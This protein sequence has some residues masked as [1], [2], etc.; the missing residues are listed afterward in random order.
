MQ[1][2]GGWARA[3][4]RC[5]PRWSRGGFEFVVTTPG[6]SACSRLSSCQFLLQLPTRDVCHFDMPDGH[7]DQM[8]CQPE[9]YPRR[10]DAG[11][12]RGRSG[13]VD[14]PGATSGH[15]DRSSGLPSGTSQDV[16]CVALR[17]ERPRAIELVAISATVGRMWKHGFRWPHR[18]DETGMGP[19]IQERNQGPQESVR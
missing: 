11:T 18:A 5:V 8:K 16:V 13:R 14:V 6:H 17:G 9:E 10:H 2:S 7:L 12:C 19:T 1:V 3:P 4:T 15:A